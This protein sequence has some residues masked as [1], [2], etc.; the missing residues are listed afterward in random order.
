M[1]F[2]AELYSLLISGLATAAI[3]KTLIYFP[4]SL[5]YDIGILAF[6]RDIPRYNYFIYV[7]GTAIN[8]SG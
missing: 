3:S 8:S 4:I 1:E 5:Q 2:N 6:K 7:S